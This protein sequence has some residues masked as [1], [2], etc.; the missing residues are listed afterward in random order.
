[1]SE[2]STL[3]QNTCPVHASGAQLMDP[4]R[5]CVHGG[6]DAAGKTVDLRWHVCDSAQMTSFPARRNPA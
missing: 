1:M 2:V 6:P 3:K 4:R 5:S